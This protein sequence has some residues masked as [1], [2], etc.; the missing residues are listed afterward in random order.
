[1]FHVE[2]APLGGI[3]D[4]LK[5]DLGVFWAKI[6]LSSDWF[7]N[8]KTQK[9]LFLQNS[10]WEM[11]KIENIHCPICTQPISSSWQN[12]LPPAFAPLEQR[13]VKA[14]FQTV[15]RLSIW[16]LEYLNILWLSQALSFLLSIFIRKAT[17]TT[18]NCNN[19]EPW[20]RLTLM[21]AIRMG[22]RW[23]REPWVFVSDT[24]VTLAESNRIKFRDFSSLG[25]YSL[26]SWSQIFPTGFFHGRYII[27]H[28]DSY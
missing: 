12:G 14:A 5:S 7:Y 18:F 8:V 22:S 1:M 17:M 16:P 6:P 15:N 9:T 13:G 25:S 4:P 3:L 24:F 19:I 23:C 11:A 27:V 2:L 21:S 26:Q 28:S 20:T 10:S